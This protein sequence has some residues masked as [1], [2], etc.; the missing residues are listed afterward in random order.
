MKA[1]L[2]L[3]AWLYSSILF[4]QNQ[5]PAINGINLNEQKISLPPGNGKFTIV[6]IAYSRDAES[7]LKKW[8]KPLYET[9][10]EK[11]QASGGLGSA[12][13]YDINF[14]FIPLI[15]GFKKAAEEFKSG[16]DKAYWPYIVDTEKTDIKEL[17]KQLEV[18]DKS[19]P[20]F[21]VIN[22]EGKIVLT[23]SGN[24]QEAKL[25]KLEEAVE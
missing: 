17:Q 7:D 12:D 20:Y 15:S 8:L 24:Y 5:F 18:K 16:T 1:L 9:F 22:K 4:S 25:N 3:A 13:I 14:Y 23:V 11:S 10:I 2:G 6:A 21:Y 19:L